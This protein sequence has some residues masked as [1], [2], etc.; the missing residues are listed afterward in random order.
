VSNASSYDSGF[1]SL[2]TP[3]T[4]RDA[5]RSATTGRLLAAYGLPSIMYPFRISAPVHQKVLRTQGWL[6]YRN[7]TDAQ[8][9]FARGYSCAFYTGHS[10]AR[11]RESDPA[12]MATTTTPDGKPKQQQQQKKKPANRGIVFAAFRLPG[13]DGNPICSSAEELEALHQDAE[14][15]VDMLIDIHMTQRHRQRVPTTPTR[16][17]VGGGGGA[18][19]GGRMMEASAPLVNI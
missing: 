6:E 14:A 3:A 12:P 19:G 16:R 10:P 7:E 11:G 9:E 4:P 18:A 1:E 8:D 13:A 2:R 5:S 17:C 15:L